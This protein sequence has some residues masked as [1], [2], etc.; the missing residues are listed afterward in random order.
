MTLRK[1][2]KAQLI[3][4]KPCGLDAKLAMFGSREARSAQ[5]AWRNAYERILKNETT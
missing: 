2:T 4:M 3:A 1:L 5:G